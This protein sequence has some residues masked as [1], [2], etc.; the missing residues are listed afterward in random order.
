[1]ACKTMRSSNA[2]PLGE[3]RGFN[4]ELSF[5]SFERTYVVTIKGKTSK[6]VELG[7]D[8]NGIITR[9]DNGIDKYAET[10]EHCKK[11][12]E[13][14]EKQFET[15]KVEVEK[16]FAQEEELKAKSA[17]LAEVNA[18][19]NTDKPDNAIIADD[20]G[21]SELPPEKSKSRDNESR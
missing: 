17:R 3:Y 20:V 18:L 8:A 1:N 15:A 13:N 4:M 7:S 12:L 16:P 2:V 9:I 21:D 10:L 5:N 19:L 6:D 14:T 11:D